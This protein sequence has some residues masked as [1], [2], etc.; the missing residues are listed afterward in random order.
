MA[1]NKNNNTLLLVGGGAVVLGGLYLYSKNKTPSLVPGTNTP[2]T[3]SNIPPAP[4]SYDDQYYKTYQYPALI[5]ANP[6]LLNSNY[7]LTPTDANNYLNNYLE[8]QQWLPTVVGSGKSFSTNQQALQYHWTHYGVAQQYS[9]VPFY[10]PKNA[11]WTHPPV[12]PSSS[13]SGGGVLSTIETVAGV[14]AMFLGP[15]DRD[16]SNEEV[17]ILVTMAP[18]TNDIIKFYLKSDRQLVGLI[19]RK[20][21]DLVSQ[22]AF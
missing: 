22:Y 14:A 17:E 9:F 7:Q 2:G 15:N 4:A 20:L 5:K 18:V 1:K 19:D 12:N 8:I 3:T 13:G 10:P 11:Q 6:N 21:N 16:L